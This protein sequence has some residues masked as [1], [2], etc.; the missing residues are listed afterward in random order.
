[1]IRVSFRLS[2]TILRPLHSD[3]AKA[4]IDRPAAIS[5]SSIDPMFFS[6]IS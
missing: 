5:S 1:M 3:A 4:S 2:L 6:L